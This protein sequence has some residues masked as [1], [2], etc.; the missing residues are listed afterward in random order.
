MYDD[1]IIDFSN[2]DNVI[3]LSA[4]DTIHSVSDLGYY[5][6]ESE[7]DGLLDLTEH[8]GGQIILAGFTDNLSASDFI[9]SDTLVV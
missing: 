7:V 9:F 1:K 6:D 4:F 2:G 3:D 5:Y 8:G